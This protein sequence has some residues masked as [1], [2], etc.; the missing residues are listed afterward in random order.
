MKYLWV[1][2]ETTGL[3]PDDSAP[4][5]IAMIFEDTSSST[6]TEKVFYLNP[7]DIDGIE[8]HKSAEFV[9]GYTKKQIQRF[10]ESKFIIPE[11]EDF[12]IQCELTNSPSKLTFVAYNSP[13]DYSHLDSLFSKYNIDFS[14]HFDKEKPMADV[15]EQVKEAFETTNLFEGLDN[16]K[17]STVAKRLGV[18]MKN[19]HDALCD[20]KT[21]KEVSKILIEHGI[22]L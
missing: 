11:I 22:N 1:D 10:E 9:H 14:S 20:I 3:R 2:T 16:K 15:L 21:A 19:A 12:L 13:F 17:L 5:Q 8:H 6:L 18:K 7:Y 4:F